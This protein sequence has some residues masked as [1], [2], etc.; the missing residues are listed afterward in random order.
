MGRGQSEKSFDVKVEEKN[1]VKVLKLKG[2]LDAYT[3]LQFEEM[4]RE[5]VQSGNYKIIV[6]MK[7]LTYISS[8]GFGVFMAFVDDVRK[9]SGDIRFCCLSEKIDEIFELLGFKHIFK[10]FKDEDSAIKSFEEQEKK[11]VRKRKK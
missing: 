7:N 8:A 1:S 9:N 10:V 11:N 6:N 2:Y 5:L 3:S 4:M